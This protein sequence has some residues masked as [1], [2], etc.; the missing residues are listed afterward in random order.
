M[1]ER[2]KFSQLPGSFSVSIP[3]QVLAAGTAKDMPL[4]RNGFGAPAKLTGARYVPQAAVTG[5]ATN[6]M[7]LSVINKGL[8][9]VGAVE[10]ASKAYEV[11]TD[12]DI[13]AFGTGELDLSATE[14]DLLMA[15]GDV[16]SL[17][18]A[19]AASGMD[20]DGVLELSFEF[21]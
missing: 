6:Y 4:F 9:G 14:A 1:G 13:V 20:M 2:S 19:E 10:M 8:L 17:D 15:D 7:T 21:A 12:D 3:L 11:P 18:K 5:H 16:L